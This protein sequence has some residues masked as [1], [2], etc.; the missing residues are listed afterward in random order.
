M[1]G[2]VLKQGDTVRTP[3]GQI[4]RVIKRSNNALF[5]WPEHTRFDLDG[6]VD[7]LVYNVPLESGEVRQYSFEALA[8][9]N[10]P[11]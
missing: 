3:G 4:G 10:N 1:T 7:V 11:R 6:D 8:V 9:L 2:R 5:E